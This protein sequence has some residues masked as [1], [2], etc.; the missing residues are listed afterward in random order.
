MGT[1]A[2]GVDSV[3]NALKEQE[4]TQ[5]LYHNELPLPLMYQRINVQVLAIIVS[6]A[7]IFRVLCLNI[8][9]LDASTKL[10]KGKAIMHLGD[11]EVFL[12]RDHCNCT[13]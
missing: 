4:P 13:T 8:K 6:C 12:R 1:K 10:C 2:V 9:L 11:L 7:L 3:G 5:K